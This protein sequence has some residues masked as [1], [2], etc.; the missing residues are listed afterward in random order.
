M[1]RC[2]TKPRKG[3]YKAMIA[4]GWSMG[5]HSAL[6]RA[7]GPVI[8]PVPIPDE[9]MGFVHQGVGG[10]CRVQKGGGVQTCPR[11]ADPRPICASAHPGDPRL[12]TRTGKKAPFPP[13]PH[14]S[15]MGDLAQF[16][17]NISTER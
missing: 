14:R 6:Q 12:S 15:V 2:L 7:V 17:P 3:T 4:A 9:R 16:F 1:S 8:L 13:A 5:S 11:G 10:V